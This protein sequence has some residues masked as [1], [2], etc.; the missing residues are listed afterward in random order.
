M[1]LQRVWEEN[2]TVYG[3]RKVWLQL[4]RKG[5]AEARCS[6]KRLMHATGLK[7]AVRGKRIRTTGAD[8]KASRPVDLVNREFTASV[9][10]QLRVVRFHLYCH[11]ERVRL[12]GICD[13]CVRPDDRWQLL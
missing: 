13:R 6:V 10:N 7:G 8:T 5:I 1:Q 11:V 12:C 3:A 9:L 4:N 2:L